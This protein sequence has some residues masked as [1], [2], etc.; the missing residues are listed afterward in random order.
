MQLRQALLLTD[1]G[2]ESPYETKTRL[3]PVG[4]GLPRTQTQIKVLNDWGAV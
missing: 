1:A 3:I 4:G 2:A